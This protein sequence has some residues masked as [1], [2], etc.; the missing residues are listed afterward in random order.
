MVRAARSAANAAFTKT[1]QG[2]ACRF[3]EKKSGRAAHFQQSFSHS[4]HI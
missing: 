2:F 1:L 3:F 4:L